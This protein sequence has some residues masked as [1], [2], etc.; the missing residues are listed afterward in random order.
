MEII[1]N[2][3]IF[4]KNTD[5]PGIYN[6]DSF[7]VEASVITDDAI[8][9]CGSLHLYIDLPEVQ[10]VRI[11]TKIILL[12]QPHLVRFENINSSFYL[13]F[14]KLKN[15]PAITLKIYRIMGLTYFPT[16]SVPVASTA[17]KTTV[18]ATAISTTLLAANPDRKGFVIVN[19]TNKVLSIDYAAS[20][21]TTDFL[22]Q[23]PQIAG[24]QASSFSESNYTGVISGIW[25][26]ATSG[27]A[28]I[29]ELT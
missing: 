26:S 7:I 25:A 28:L 21:S 10:K 5:I 29:R 12:N 18:A 11:F 3:E 17:T 6:N 23:I 19:N 15:I 14:E 16:L 2:N 1:F 4:S 8:K 9:Q 24:G 27:G 20:T 22:Q 13:S